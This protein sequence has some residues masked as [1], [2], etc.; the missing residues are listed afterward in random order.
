[1]SAI[2]RS[3]RAGPPKF[4]GIEAWLDPEL[5][6]GILIVRFITEFF[7]EEA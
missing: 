6:W 3:T 5:S 2:Q 1:M 7:S 4:Y